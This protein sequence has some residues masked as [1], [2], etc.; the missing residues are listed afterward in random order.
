MGI[1]GNVSPKYREN[2]QN[3]ISKKNGRITFKAKKLAFMRKHNGF[4]KSMAMHKWNV[5]TII[6]YTV[7][8]RRSYT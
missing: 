7:Y 8:L 1:R 6:P 2:V 5:I 4:A 3:S